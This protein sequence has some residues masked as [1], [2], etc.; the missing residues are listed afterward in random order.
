[1]PWQM[2]ELR[3]RVA[4]PTRFRPSVVLRRVAEAAAPD[5]LLLLVGLTLAARFGFV[6]LLLLTGLVPHNGWYFTNEDQIQYFGFADALAGG[7]LTPTYTTIGYGTLLAPFAS[8]AEFVLQAVP[9]VVILQVALA[10]PAAALLYLAGTRLL[11]RRSAALGTALWL[12]SP[13]FLGPLWTPSYAE[14]FWESPGWIGLDIAVDYVSTLFAIAVLVLASGARDDASVRRGLLVGTV[15]GAAFLVKPSNIVLVGTALLALSVWRR[16]RSAAVALAAAAIVYTPQLVFNWR[17]F[18]DPTAY[19]YGRHGLGGSLSATDTYD[20]TSITYIPRVF[21]KLIVSNYTGPVILVGAA[22]ALLLTWRRYRDARWLVVAPVV[23]YALAFGTLYYAI[24]GTL[25][26]FVSPALPALCLAVAA[27]LVGRP[28][29]SR[30]PAVRAPARAGA[31]LALAVVAA[32]AGYAVWIHGAPFRSDTATVASMAPTASV[33]GGEVR[34]VWQEP[35]SPAEL[36]YLVVRSR[37]RDPDPETISRGIQFG[38]RPGEG[39]LN[40][41]EERAVDRPGPGVWWYRIAITPYYR[42]DRWTPAPA[43][44]QSP[45]LRVVVAG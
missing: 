8:G 16:W 20:P 5:R 35:D 45:P 23:G 3:A 40:T 39:I 10:A 15:A 13:I 4:P 38:G 43:M 36:T 19:A 22:L 17:L 21:G 37:R 28:G 2:D 33:V 26:R 44:G 1:M 24:S 30:P 14:R 41:S 18:G 34:L 29:K 12:A 27:A 31:A 32:A 7:A 25:L 6:A 9:A 42:T 11:D